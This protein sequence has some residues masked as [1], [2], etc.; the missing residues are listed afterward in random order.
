MKSHEA[1]NALALKKRVKKVH[2]KAKFVGS[3]YTLGAIAML[4]LVCL[5]LI[6]LNGID[7]WI[8]NFWNPILDAFNADKRNLL[9]LIIAVFYALAVFVCLI[10]LFKCFGKFG[11]L[12]K[13]SLRYVNGS[14][15]NKN[16]MEK[17]GKYFSSSFAAVLI[18]FLEIYLVL[19]AANTVTFTMYAYVFLAVGL[20]IHLLAGLISGTVSNFNTQNVGG[21]VEEEKREVGMFVYFFRNIIQIAAVVGIVWYF[22]KENAI[23]TIVAN[24]LAGKNPF[25]GDLVKDVLPLALQLAL[26]LCLIVMIKHATAPT[27]FNLHGIYGKGMKKFRVFAFFTTLVSGGIFAIDFFVKKVNPISYT[28]AIIAGIAFVAFLIDCIFKSRAKEEDE[29]VV[30]ESTQV[31]S[32][33]PQPAFYPQPMPQ[34]QAQQVICPQMP[35]NMQARVPQQPNYIPMYYPYPVAQQPQV[36]QQPI[37]I[38]IYYPCAACMPQ[39][40]QQPQRV[41]IPEP[42]VVSVASQIVNAEKPTPAPAPEKI[43]PTPAPKGLKAKEKE[44]PVK[45][46]SNVESEKFNPNREYRVRCPKC[47]KELIVTEKSPY[48]RC[49]VCDKV[50]KIQKFQTYVQK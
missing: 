38:P 12:T 6:K 42:S 32:M 2:S 1:T 43:K 49:P 34:Q 18:L 25:T 45:E 44:E 11:W 50:F 35:Q 10:N 29:N 7:L 47:G 5:P 19:P 30:M 9:A 24:G 8:V 14:Q 20:A 37:Y 41:Q 36:I 4:V 21:H 46:Y 23:A 15:R 48:H 40:P 39:Q 22:V 16:A 27:E 31:D 13:R 26:V 3:L 17:I 33:A 28:Y